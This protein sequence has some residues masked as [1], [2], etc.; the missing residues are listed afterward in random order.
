MSYGNLKTAH[1]CAVGRRGEGFCLE[2]KKK[3]DESKHEP[4]HKV[5]FCSHVLVL[6][7]AI[8]LDSEI[9]S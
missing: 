5:S 6:E 8:V 3:K 1:E 2:E 7:Q 9:G 4:R